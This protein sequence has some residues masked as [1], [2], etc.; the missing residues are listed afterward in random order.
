VIALGRTPVAKLRLLGARCTLPSL[1]IGN[2]T[3]ST[4]TA[5]LTGIRLGCVP[6]SKSR[7]GA[8]TSATA[9]SQSIA[10]PYVA[11]LA[12]AYTDAARVMYVCA[13]APTSA[14]ENVVPSVNSDAT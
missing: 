9:Y 14:T 2:G 6:S 8:R 7:F 3:P 12:F 5:T 13:E 4:D 11:L 10:M 1:A